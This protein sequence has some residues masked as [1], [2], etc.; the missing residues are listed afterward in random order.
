MKGIKLRSKE[1]NGANQKQTRGVRKRLDSTGVGRTYDTF[2]TGQGI[3]CLQQ[4]HQSFRSALGN[5]QKTWALDSTRLRKSL[6]M[7]LVLPSHQAS[8]FF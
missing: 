2:R 4:S 3:S 6:G 1:E 8:S 5:K 7:R